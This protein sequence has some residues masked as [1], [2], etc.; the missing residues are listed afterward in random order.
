MFKD[1]RYVITCKNGCCILRISKGKPVLRISPYIRESK[2]IYKKILRRLNIA[3]SI[4][5]KGT[6]NIHTIYIDRDTL[7]G[8]KR[9]VDIHC[10][11][12]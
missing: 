2:K 11:G 12:S 4:I 7:L 10:E 9:L 8:L 1:L 6:Y 3:I 5:F